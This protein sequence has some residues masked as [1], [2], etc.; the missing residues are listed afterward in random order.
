M[1]KAKTLRH[2]IQ[3]KKELALPELKDLMAATY[4]YQYD[5][6][7]QLEKLIESIKKFSKELESILP[8]FIISKYGYFR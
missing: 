7:K 3:R 2:K 6:K 1:S 4:L 5:F 8:V